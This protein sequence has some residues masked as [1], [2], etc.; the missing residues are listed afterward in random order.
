MKIGYCSPFNPMKS[1]ISDF[2]EELVPVLTTQVEV[3]VFSPT[4]LENKNIEKCCEIHPLK[5]LDN[6][7]LR[8]SLDIIVYHVGNSY[9]C[10]GE[11]VDYMQ[12]YPGIL[13]LHDVGLHHFVAEQISKKQDWS[14]YV[15]LS[16]YSHGMKGRK[17]AEDFLAGKISAPW[18]TYSSEMT[19]TRPFVE[20]ARGIIVHS[21]FAKQMVLGIYDKNPIT[22]IML[23]T[24]RI[25][26]DAEKFKRSCREKLGL[27][28]NELII[29]S[30][31]FAT[32]QKRII[33]I[34]DA[35][36]KIKKDG[37]SSFRYL[38]VGEAQ[39]ELKIKEKIQERNLDDNVIV[40]GF[41]ELEEFKAYM[42]ACDF[43]LN[44]RYPTQ[45]ESSASL[46]RMLGMGKPIIV[47]DIGTFSDYPDEIV[48]KV[49]Y[50]EQEVEEIY[51]AIRELSRDRRQLKQR[52]QAALKYAEENCDIEKNAKS[53][54]QFFEKVC[55]GTWLPDEEDVLISHLCE[56]GLT[57]DDYT[58]ELWERIHILV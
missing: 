56:L 13:E 53:Y 41:T 49:S 19:M 18:D 6:Y 26:E 12:K 23:H 24:E 22:S 52:T 47:T 7:K 17:I 45:G 20:C 25:T 11:I 16:E 51:Q 4:A 39:E 35:L 43:C 40:T 54:V 55:N 32:H 15:D 10:H 29:G 8:K 46:H 48:K 36:K 30:F 28:K 50:G 3:V 44:L 31:G 5:D 33:Q 58:T 1:G 38:I 2:S 27:S 9:S 34:L 21:E 57:D 42:G 37:N 14:S